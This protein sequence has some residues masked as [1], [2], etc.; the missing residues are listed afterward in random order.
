MCFN[1]R[2]VRSVNEHA[3]LAHVPVTSP[4]VTLTPKVCLDIHFHFLFLYVFRDLLLDQLPLSRTH[5]DRFGS[6]T[7]FF[8]ESGRILLDVKQTHSFHKRN[9]TKNSLRSASLKYCSRKIKMM[10]MMMVK[11]ELTFSNSQR[12]SV[13]TA[14]FY[15]Y[16]FWDGHSWRPFLTYF[17]V[18]PWGRL[19]PSCSTVREL[20]GIISTETVK[21]STRDQF[22]FIKEG[23]KL[24]QDCK[25]IF[26]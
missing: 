4:V 16:F 12:D 18:A 1:I 6:L 11:E 20:N 10:M 7:V 17:L 26:S 8:D 15:F 19:R 3:S 14:V 22:N 23:K 21:S 25:P 5:H 13:S 24:I 2:W 9:V